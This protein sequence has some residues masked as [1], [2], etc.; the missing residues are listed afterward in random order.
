MDF[1]GSAK[2]NQ[3]KDLLVPVS[4][5]VVPTSTDDEAGVL[6]QNTIG[7][8]SSLQSTVSAL[9]STINSF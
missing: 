6:L 4:T 8:V 7:M 1:R 3:G 9:R 5:T 2:L